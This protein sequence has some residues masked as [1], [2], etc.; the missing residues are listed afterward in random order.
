MDAEIAEMGFAESVFNKICF[1]RPL[2]QA[3]DLL[4]R[5]SMP[6]AAAPTLPSVVAFSPP[7]TEI[8]LP[9]D[10]PST[11]REST[12]PLIIPVEGAPTLSLD[13]FIENAKRDLQTVFADK[14]TCADSFGG[15]V[16]EKSVE[17]VFR[18]GRAG[19]RNFN[20]ALMHFQIYVC[21][22]KGDLLNYERNNRVKALIVLDEEIVK[23]GF[24]WEV[25]D[26]I[27]LMRFFVNRE[28]YITEKQ[29]KARLKTLRPL[30]SVAGQS[31][32]SSQ[33]PSVKPKTILPHPFRLQNIVAL[34]GL[35]AGG[36]GFLW[37]VLHKPKKDHKNIDRRTPKSKIPMVLFGGLFLGS[38]GFLVLTN[39]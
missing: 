8:A 39:Q 17:E 21:R 1:C 36:A 31:P 5:S 3:R 22:V 6:A 13:E 32:S 7:P 37:A 24:D 14:V 38:A 34:V 10:L 27:R 2:D 25:F 9:P 19:E 33:D 12:P 16:Y 30:P 20:M 4:S 15:P 18:S 29:Y 11:E 35:V 28:G 23:K 26:G